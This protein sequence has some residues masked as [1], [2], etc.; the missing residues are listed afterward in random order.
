MQYIQLIFLHVELLDYVCKLDP[1]LITFY[2]LEI[3]YLNEYLV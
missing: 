3:S 2:G 1:T